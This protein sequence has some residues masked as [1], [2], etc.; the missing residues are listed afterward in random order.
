MIV[1][2]WDGADGGEDAVEL[3]RQ[4]AFC[5]G[6]E[7]VQVSVIVT[8]ASPRGRGALVRNG[9]RT[10]VAPSVAQGLSEVASEVAATAIVVGSSQRGRIGRT[11]FGT[12]LNQLADISPC[13]IAVA[14]RGYAKRYAS[15]LRRIETA[16]DESPASQNAVEVAHRIA[17]GDR[18]HVQ[19]SY[20]DADIRIFAD[21]SDPRARHPHAC[22]LLIA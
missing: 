11:L 22:A 7:I 19:A 6:A 13:P 10:V 18:G 21:R 16:V 2:G 12:A 14:P 9:G 8:G 20:D 5:L 1:V 17:A 15:R 3:G 4:L